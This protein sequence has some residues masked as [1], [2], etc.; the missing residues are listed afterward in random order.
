MGGKEGGRVANPWA[1]YH[2]LG[3]RRR[4]IMHVFENV[5][6]HGNGMIH[7]YASYGRIIVSSFMSADAEA[8]ASPTKGKSGD[9]KKAPLP[10]PVR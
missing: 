2:W 7:L 1:S 3:E 6:M 8:P 9:E 5:G 10:S 4:C